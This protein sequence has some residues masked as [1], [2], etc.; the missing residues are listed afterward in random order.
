MTNRKQAMFNQLHMDSM[1]VDVAEHYRTD[2]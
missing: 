2:F 1:F